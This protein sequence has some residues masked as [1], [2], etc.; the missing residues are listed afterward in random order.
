MSKFGKKKFGSGYQK[1]A[2][3]D[4]KTPKIPQKRVFARSIDRMHILDIL[5]GTTFGKKYRI[6]PQNI[7]AIFHWP[8]MIILW[9]KKAAKCMNIKSKV[10][11]TPRGT[12]GGRI[13]GKLTNWKN[14][15][16]MAFDY[17][18][19]TLKPFW[20]TRRVFQGIKK[21]LG[22]W[23]LA[24]NAFWPTV[25]HHLQYQYDIPM[26][27]EPFWSTKLNLI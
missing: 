5:W 20:S 7:F 23:L 18:Y 1:L 2:N 24:K 17:A 11:V 8:I 22:G 19:T 21:K 9:L 4:S 16:R 25:G 3:F 27:T 12:N 15:Y 10:I 13:V 14:M 26:F 6:I